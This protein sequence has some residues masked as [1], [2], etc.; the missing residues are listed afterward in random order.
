MFETSVLYKANMDATE[1]VVVNQGG[2][3]SGKTY[4]I[5]QLLFTIAIMKPLQVVTVVGQDIPNLKKGAYRDAKAIYGSSDVVRK[6]FGKPNETERVFT[7]RNGSIVE[8]TSYTDEQDAKSGKRD[9][10]FLNEAN[11]IPYEVYRQLE[12][13][14]RKKVF[15]DYNP[16]AKFWVH[17]E[18]LGKPDVKLI[19]SDHRHNP[20]LDEE[21][22]ARIEGITDPQ[23]FKVYARGLTGK[24]EGLLFPESELTFEDFT[25]VDFSEAQYA[26]AVGDPADRGGDY[27]SMPFLFVFAIGDTI[28][29]YVRDVL[30]N[31]NG[32]E[33]NTSVI[34]DK[35]RDMEIEA[36]FVECNGG[37][38]SH[39]V[40]LKR[41]GTEVHAITNSINKMVR[42]FSQYEFIIKY[43]VFDSNYKKKPEYRDFTRNLTTF[44]KEGKNE[45]DDAPDALATAASI[46]KSKYKKVLYG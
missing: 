33:A 34:I 6:W 16:T 35:A 13:R 1:R 46:V 24:I 27:Y 41:G 25:G 10:L 28:R 26:F 15:I 19:I 43:F 44:L 32:I 30:F 9:Y 8:F 22:H 37:W 38:V 14:T 36:I 18:L 5:L 7:C 23:F 3:S 2:T 20:F 4:S 11:G 29:V 45:N 39:A 40:A 17:E 12:I 21:T 31:K 42:I